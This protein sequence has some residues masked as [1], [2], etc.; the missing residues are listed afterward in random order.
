MYAAGRRRPE[1]EVRLRQVHLVRLVVAALAR[2]RQRDMSKS[3]VGQPSIECHARQR[4][5]ALGTARAS[6][7]Q[8]VVAHRTHQGGKG[9]RAVVSWFGEHAGESS[10]TT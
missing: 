3:A 6:H 7:V 4:N 1:T 8:K 5:D 2:E 9:E 10:K